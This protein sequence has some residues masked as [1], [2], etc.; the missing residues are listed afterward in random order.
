MP[1]IEEYWAGVVQRLQAEVDIFARLVRHK[2]TQGQE[3]EAALARLLKSFVPQRLG[4]GTGMVIDSHDTY[5]RQADVILYE[6]SDEPLVLAQTTHLIHPMESVRAS[7]EVKTRLRG[8]DIKD[9]L[10]KKSSLNALRPAVN[11]PDGSSHPLF[12]LLAYDSQLAPERIH[13]RFIAAPPEQRPDLYFVLDP[14]VLGGKRGVFLHGD[15]EFSSG[16]A[17]LA[18]PDERSIYQTVASSVLDEAILI[19]GRTHPVVNWRDERYLGDPARALLLFVEALA[20]MLANQQG[21]AQPILSHYLDDHTRRL[22]W[23]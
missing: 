7:I 8:D 13:E 17:L 4:V 12:I 16:L 3:N 2:A 22:E 20:R 14:G 18:N 5:A 23:L 1:V 9:C 11:N 15:T 21:R 6:Q 10:I 19:S